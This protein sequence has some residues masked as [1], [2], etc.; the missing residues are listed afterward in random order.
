MEPRICVIV[1]VVGV[2]FIGW[3]GIGVVT[4]GAINLLR[5]FVRSA[6]RHSES[7]GTLARAGMERT[8]VPEIPVP[9]AA[10]ASSVRYPQAG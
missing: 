9:A 4:I 1:T 5:W 3:L 7:A 2:V 8:S 6:S 10:S